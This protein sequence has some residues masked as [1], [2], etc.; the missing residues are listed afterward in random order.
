MLFE[1]EDPMEASNVIDANLSVNAE[2]E[3]G[4]GV[5]RP[6]ILLMR[7]QRFAFKAGLICAVFIVPIVVISFILTKDKLE[8]MDVARKEIAGLDY[9]LPAYAVLEAAQAGTQ[10]ALA[11]DVSGLSKSRQQ[12]DSAFKRLEEVEAKLGTELG[13]GKSFGEMAQKYKALDSAGEGLPKFSAYRR[14][15]DS[16]VTLLSTSSD[17]SGLVLDPEIATYYLGDIL[18]TSLPV[19]SGRTAQV[20]AAGASS[21]GAKSVSPLMQRVFSD[22]EVMLSYQVSRLESALSKVKVA[23][24]QT[25]DSLLSEKMLVNSN[26]MFKFVESNIIDADAI[27][28]DRSAFSTISTQ[29]LQSQSKF[30]ENTFL[31]L[32]NL[33]NQRLTDLRTY[34]YQLFAGL[35]V[36]LLL[37]AYLFYCFF[38]VTRGGM[39]LISMHLQELSEG[40]LRRIPRNPLGKDEAADLI[41]D[42]Q[43]MY[44][45]LHQLIRRVR[46]SARELNITATGITKSSSDLSS[47]TDSAAANLE[48]QSAAISQIGATVANTAERANMAATFANKNAEVAKQGGQVFEDV[49][50]TMRDIQASS[51]KINDIIGV[52]DGIAFQTNILALNAAV[53]AARAGESGRGFAVVASEVRSLAKRSADAAREIKELIASSVEKVATGTRIVE[54]AGASMVDVVTNAGQIKSYL[55]EI[56]VAAKE[57]SIGVSECGAALEELDNSTQQNSALVNETTEAAE[58]LR[59]QAELMVHEIANFK[60]K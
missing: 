30:A 44:Q 29:A 16:V 34:S 51:E 15:Q 46:H 54:T 48:E 58:A 24:P 56:S 11:N 32:R 42:L 17:G 45:S 1:N 40:D 19:L 50:L 57:Q 47:R 37:V 41:V 6:G 4:H 18:T 10:M 3:H 2:F 27:T 59:N 49:V 55:D 28:A 20:A 7:R 21:L 60:V 22:N 36:M 35:A 23:N 31:A 13:T 5:W 14:L 33:L 38:L 9:M 53:E 8:S 26:A 12:L 43:K 25:Y 52:I 39:Q